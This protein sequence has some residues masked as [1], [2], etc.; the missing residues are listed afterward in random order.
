LTCIPLYKDDQCAFHNLARNQGELLIKK[1]SKMATYKM[2]SFVLFILL[3]IAIQLGEF[4]VEG[5]F[6]GRRG[7]SDDS[8]S[9]GFGVGVGVNVGVGGGGNSSGA[10]G[11]VDIGVDAGVGDS[12]G[13]ASLGVDVGVDVG[14]GHN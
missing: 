3:G 6:G 13:G 7:L 11:G 1:K 12:N 10:G 8:N 9:T 14:G 5:G 2:S 4:H